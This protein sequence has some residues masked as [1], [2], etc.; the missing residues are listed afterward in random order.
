[1]PIIL[2]SELSGIV[3]AI[4][5]GVS[6][7]KVGDE[8]YG[9]TNAQFSG[10][11][12]EYAL[13]L[14]RMIAQKPKTL[15]F[16]EAASAP[17]VTVTAWQMLFDYAEV[18]AGQTVLIHG[19]AGNV[20]AYA[21]QL[22]SQAGLHVIATAASADL[23]YVRGLG[24]ERI[25]DFRRER[26]EDSLA[27]VD[28]VLDTIGGDT[29]QRSLRVL[30]PGGILVSVVSRVPEAMQKRYG[31]RS[32]YFYV[33]VTTARLNKITELFD[34]GKL[35]TDVGTV[36]PLEEA[37]TAHEMLGG[38]PHKRGKIVLSIAA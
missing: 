21:V 2:G 27:G 14:A 3:E 22:A 25:L 32:A 11:Y 36:L 29:Q 18:T 8:V 9:A 13:A 1:M 19:A 26:F 15:N 34:N 16:I 23:E 24:A 37:R 30:K 6:G 28:V 31:V 33:D 10:A 38:A 5:S 7:F 12:A 4:G 20:G 17:V 35:V